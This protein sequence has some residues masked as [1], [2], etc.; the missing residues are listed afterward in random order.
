ML[1]G[2][3]SISWFLVLVSLCSLLFK[4]LPFIHD[5]RRKWALCRQKICRLDF[6]PKGK[7]SVETC[8]WKYKFEVWYAISWAH[9]PLADMCVC[10]NAFLNFLSKLTSFLDCAGYKMD[11]HDPDSNYL[12]LQFSRYPGPRSGSG[13]RGRRWMSL[14]GDNNAVCKPFLSKF[15]WLT[16]FL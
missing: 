13:T 2:F 3:P 7:L 6:F 15:L 1:C 10:I 9:H 11:E 4:I 16:S 12:R 14:S 8:N 5:F